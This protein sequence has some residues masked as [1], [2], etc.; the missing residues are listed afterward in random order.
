MTIREECTCCGNI[1]YLEN[2]VEN[3][4]YEAFECWNCMQRSFLPDQG[5]FHCMDRL[6]ISEEEAKDKL[7][8]FEVITTNGSSVPW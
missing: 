4:G 6:E 7:E 8:G 2:N 1:N 5:L 3:L